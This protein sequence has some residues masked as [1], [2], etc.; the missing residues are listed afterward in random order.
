MLLRFPSS[1]GLHR[2]T[3]IATNSIIIRGLIEAPI[4]THKSLAVWKDVG[5]FHYQPRG[6]EHDTSNPARAY[7]SSTQAGRDA[8]RTFPQYDLSVHQGRRISEANTA[9]ATRGRM[10][11]IGRR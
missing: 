8:H 6:D 2:K 11:R 10:A 5:V 7:F 9:R 1:V 4:P 3:T